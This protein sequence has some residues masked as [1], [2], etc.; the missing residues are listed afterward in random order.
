MQNI[1]CDLSR[2]VDV[3]AGREYKENILKASL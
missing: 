1:L 3:S 2:Q